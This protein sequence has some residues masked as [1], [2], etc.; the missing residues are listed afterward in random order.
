MGNTVADRLI[1][2]PI[3]VKDVIHQ[4][5]DT[6]DII[7]VI[8]YADAHKGNDVVAFANTLKRN[9]R[10]ATLKAVFDFVFENIKYVEDA[11]GL[12]DV[13][14]PSQT[15]HSGYGDCKSMS[16]LVAALLDALGFKYKYRFVSYKKKHPVTHVYVVSEGVYLDTVLGVFNKQTDFAYKKD[17]APRKVQIGKLQYTPSVHAIEVGSVLRKGV[18]AFGII[19][20]LRKITA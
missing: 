10:K 9:S 15:Y 7:D 4:N 11:R 1:K 19:Y 18:I 13:K 16:I 6:S 5:G 12:E 8:L 3:G 17:I 20:L 14:S 2:Q